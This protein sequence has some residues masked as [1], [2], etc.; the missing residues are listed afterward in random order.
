ME[1]SPDLR[2]LIET[3]PMIRVERTEPIRLVDVVDM[4]R[5]DGLE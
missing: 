2:A 4:A 5:N 3:T 1:I